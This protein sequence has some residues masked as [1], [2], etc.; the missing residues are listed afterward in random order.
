M[1]IVRLALS[2]PYTFIV[3]AILIFILGLLSILK[4]PKDIFPN[5]NIPVVSVVWSYTGLP[6]E[7]MAGRITSSFERALPTTVNNIEH[8][9]SQS[10]LG[11]SITKIFFH[12]G[13]D[14]A[15][16]LSQV[17]AIAQTLLR[18]LPPGTQPP[19]VLS[20]NAST[21]PVLQLVLSSRSIL[22]RN[23][24]DL[25]NNFIRTQ[26]ASVEGA[27]IPYPYGGKFRQVNVDLDP[28]AMRTFSISPKEVNE[29]L[30]RQNLIIPAGTQKI[31]QY[32]YYVQLN[33]SPLEI[34][35]LN[36]LP[37]KTENGDVIYMR[38]IGQVHDGSMPQTNIVRVDGQPA[39]LMPI[40]K[41]GS[42][43]TLTIIEGIKAL[44]PRVRAS[45]PK[46]LN[47]SLIGDQSL[48]VKAAID[49]VIHESLIAAL[50]TSLMIYLFIGSLLSTL[51]IIISIPLAILV[52]IITFSN[53]GETLNIMTLGGLALAVGI[54]VD[55]AT[56][57][58]ENIN[59][60]L[61]KGEKTIPA[62][63]KGAEQIAMPALVSTLCICIVFLPIFSFQGVSYFLFS[64]LAQAVIFAMLASY[65]LS[66]TLLPTLA[67][68][69]LKPHSP[70][71]PKAGNIISRFQQRFSTRFENF[72]HRYKAT[73]E[74]VLDHKKA[75]I[76]GFMSFILLS[77]LLLFPWLGSN[78]FPS[79]DGGQ[80]KL[81]VQAPTGTRIEETARTCGQISTRI[82]QLISTEEVDSIVENIGLP[83]SGI[84]LSYSN[85]APIGASSADIFITLKGNHLPT[86][87]YVSK[88]REDLPSY[89]PNVEFSFLPADMVGQ[90]L[91][92]GIPAPIDIQVIGLKAATNRDF[93][94][95]LLDELR[96]IPGI[97]DAHI[98][99][100]FNYPQL[101]VKV[102]RSFAQML[103]L[104][105]LDAA[106]NLLISLSGSFQTTPNF[107]L[108]P[109][110]GV[111][112]QLVT[113]TPQYK[114]DSL[115]ELKNIPLASNSNDPLIIGSLFELNRSGSAAVESHYNVEPVIDIFAAVQ[116]RD[117][118]SVAK[119]IDVMI[120]KSK[121]KLPK[122][123]LVVTRGQIKTQQES[124]RGLYTG[125]IFAV[126]LAY[127]LIVV[128]FQ[129][130]LN[131]LIIIMALPAALAGIIWMLFLTQTTL[132]VPALMGTIMTMGVATANSILM[133]SFA[134]EEIKAGKDLRSAVLN[135]GFTRI[136]PVLMTALAMI[137]GMM[138]MALSIGVGAE[139][140]AP[141]GRAVIGGLLFATISTLFFVPSVF[142]WIY[143]H[144]AQKEQAQQGKKNENTSF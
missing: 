18:A 4:T 52:S 28:K 10:L 73:L 113:Q 80:I 79:V 20:Y 49:N 30:N 63:L 144:K 37:I 39:V 75:F 74:R 24:F 109:K 78:F 136:R 114:I 120:T 51:M 128:N 64:P 57:T 102:N 126:L 125:L 36:Q 124:F 135:A 62:I 35:E 27:S 43:S 42:A 22:E 34:E 127:L 9:E 46:A 3:F 65:F 55:D 123:S 87:D 26:F 111:S 82:R 29:A 129:S 94:N 56:V 139:Q 105:Q 48:F 98:Y 86:P 40:Q 142:F 1:W 59:W 84:N 104:T 8:I 68:Y 13:V 70:E 81:H 143:D 90:I 14:I 110:N 96:L 54:L 141:L 32:E 122:G 107:W 91:N 85:S 38:D 12:E 2:R 118:G 119:D 31:G 131:P 108:N 117:L 19:L 21:V 16:A 99:Q 61:E 132:S 67:K 103:E 69:W 7:Q 71:K 97:V 106:S 92:F 47:L 138:P 44:L 83:V 76:F 121:P 58:I 45:M 50:L 60:H 100:R 89:F 11:M 6:P 15:V 5:I 101:N 134:L 17:T 130:W 133:V 140:N 72:R 33:A 137:I 115:E 23:L 93:A 41:T 116:D 66:R 88:L 53:L 77:A 25:G 95:A 112:Y